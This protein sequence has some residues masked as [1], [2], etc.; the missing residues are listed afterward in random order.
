MSRFTKHCS[1]QDPLP[2][3]HMSLPLDT[4]SEY[5]QQGSFNN[6][7]KYS[8]CG[9]KTRLQKRLS[10]GY[11]GVNS[12]DRACKEHDIHYSKF[13]T[14]KT[15]NVADNIL[16]S[17]ASQ[18]ALNLNLPEYERKDANLVTGLM[19]MKSRFGMGSKKILK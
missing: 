9:P 14:T 15:R 13:K 11:K 4:P 1:K 19:G 5:I 16:A 2:E 6:T 12:I 18:I 7:G 17:R 8:F 10:E 3:L